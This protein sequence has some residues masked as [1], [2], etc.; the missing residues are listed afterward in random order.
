LDD[1]ATISSAFHASATI[2]STTADTAASAIWTCGCTFAA[3]VD[4]APLASASAIG[5]CVSADDCAASASSLLLPT[6]GPACAINCACA[7]CA[8]MSQVT[9]LDNLVQR[10]ANVKKRKSEEEQMANDLEQK[11]EELQMIFSNRQSIIT[12]CDACLDD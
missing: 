1:A 2:A 12:R 4:T 8:E 3:T 9:N 5:A 7:D 11:I 6:R 10:V